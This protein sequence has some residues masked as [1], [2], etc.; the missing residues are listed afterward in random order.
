MVAGSVWWWQGSEVDI[1]S[2]GTK[3]HGPVTKMMFLLHVHLLLRGESNVK[4]HM[5][6]TGWFK[7]WGVVGCLSIPEAMHWWMTWL[8]AVMPIRRRSLRWIRLMEEIQHQLRLVVSPIICRLFLHPR[9]LFGISSINSSSKISHPIQETS[10]N[11][12]LIESTVAFLNLNV[13][14]QMISWNMSGWHH[15]LCL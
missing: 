10:N 7:S 12:V 14:E 9:W 5:F 6:S 13:Y 3:K 4:Q 1:A 11:R 2:E 8:T 15:L